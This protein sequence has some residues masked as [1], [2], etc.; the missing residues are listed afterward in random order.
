[1]GEPGATPLGNNG[2]QD[3][4]TTRPHASVTISVL[5]LLCTAGC[6][7]NRGVT[8]AHAEENDGSR[9]P[10]DPFA[11][12]TRGPGQPILPG[13]TPASQQGVS[14]APMYNAF[15]EA[16]NTQSAALTQS[17]DFDSAENVLRVSTAD[18]GADFDPCTSP[19]GQ[20]VYFAS[21]RH[22]PTSD[23]YVKRID[24]TAVTQLT[25]DPAQDVMP[26]VSPD[27]KR[28]AFCSNRNGSYDIYVMNAPGVGSGVPQAVQ[29]TSDPGQELHPTWA[30]D[31]KTLAFCRLGDHSDRWEVWVTDATRPGAMKFL[32][33]GL[34]PSWQPGGDKIAFQ[35]ARERGG[36]FFGIWTVDYLNGE[37]TNPTEVI[38][39]PVAAA[40]NPSWSP[41]GQYIAFST[42]I[43]PEK[44]GVAP[45]KATPGA[46]AMPALADLWIVRSDGTGRANLTSGWFANLSP[47]WGSDGRIYFVSN[48]SGTDNLWSVGPAQAVVAASGSVQPANQSEGRETKTAQT[49]RPSKAAP[50]A[51]PEHAESPA[52]TQGGEKPQTSDEE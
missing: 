46:P 51:E 9:R 40:I 20:W 12:S 35:R 23:L 38:S 42:V 29:I 36:R 5:C 44:P 45:S 19:D 1:M 26:S 15:G 52:M 25:S 37:A 4:S 47:S 10:A 8:P 24:G 18:E 22:R 50:A 34:F 30:P 43:N 11:V 21:T 17:S 49:A 7:S 33:Y 32:T 39:S 41:D 2:A 27:G 48:R 28:V 31:G 6:A 3:M 13:A 16:P 14:S